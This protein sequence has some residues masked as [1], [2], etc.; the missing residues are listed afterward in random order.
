MGLAMA[1]TSAMRACSSLSGSAS[2]TGYRSHA[3][4]DSM[5][6]FIDDHEPLEKWVEP[7]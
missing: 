3:H 4:L 7:L 5:K 2:T 6:D 1:Q